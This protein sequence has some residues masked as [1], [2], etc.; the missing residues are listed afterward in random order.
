MTAAEPT[1][2]MTINTVDDHDVVLGTIARRLVIPTAHN[3]RVAHALLENERGEILLQQLARSRDRHPLAWGA[4]VAAYLFDG[5]TYVD[6]IRRRC[7]QE[8]GQDAGGLVF[9]GRTA[10]R[11]TQSVKF[12][13][14]FTGRLGSSLQIDHS[15]IEAVELLT[16]DRIDAELRTGQR[17]FTPT[18]RHVYSHLRPFL[19]A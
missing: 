14:L 7:Q 19:R 12:I 2:D 4:S 11:D 8:L 17:A 5:E 18:F 6:A 10:M 16:P 15:H 13:G 1:P 3:F 9:R